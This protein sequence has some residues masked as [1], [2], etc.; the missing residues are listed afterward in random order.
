LIFTSGKILRVVLFTFDFVNV[1]RGDVSL[2]VADV[3][4]AVDVEGVDLLFHRN[5]DAS[6]GKR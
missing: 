2:D 3:G 4:D 1:H 6:C 5:V